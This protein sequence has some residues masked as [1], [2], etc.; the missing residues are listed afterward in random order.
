MVYNTMYI[1][2]GTDMIDKSRL[3]FNLSFNVL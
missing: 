2:H 3:Q 1:I